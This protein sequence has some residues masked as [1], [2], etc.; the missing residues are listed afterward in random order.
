MSCVNLVLLQ[1]ESGDGLVVGYDKADVILIS[2]RADVV[3]ESSS[4]VAHA[5]CGELDLGD[6]PEGVGEVAGGHAEG[7]LQI[8]IADDSCRYQFQ[9]HDRKVRQWPRFRNLFV[10]NARKSVISGHELVIS[11]DMARRICR[12]SL[13]FY[14]LG[15]GVPFQLLIVIEGFPCSDS[16][17]MDGQLHLLASGT[18]K[19]RSRFCLEETFSVL[20][21]ECDVAHRGVTVRDQGIG[22]VF[23]HSLKFR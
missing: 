12:E 21:K 1:V 2:P 17:L 4:M 14:C 22:D 16:A 23:R 15:Q 7:Q 9:A 6:D 13:G 8:E 19:H 3:P 10:A 5:W 18:G 11:A 20:V